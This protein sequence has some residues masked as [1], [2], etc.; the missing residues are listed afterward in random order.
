ME[1]HENDRNET[2]TYHEMPD[3][4]SWQGQ[5]SQYSSALQPEPV[6]E[7]VIAGA[8]GAFLFAL[9]GGILYFIVYQFGFIAGICGLI[10]VI[11]SMFGYQL[12]SGN[13]SSLKGTVIAIIMSILS[14][15]LAEYLSLSYVIYDLYKTDLSITFFDAVQMTPDFLAE[16]EVMIAFLKDLG[17]AFVLGAIASAGRIRRR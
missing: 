7:N 9:I 12:F 5:T 2:P 3:P 16:S 4:S 14:I 11:L 8:V 13:K 10:T 6:H 17:I 1:N 15:V